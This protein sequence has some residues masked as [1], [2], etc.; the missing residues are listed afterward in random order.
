MAAV[1]FHVLGRGRGSF[2]EEVYAPLRL[3]AYLLGE[4]STAGEEPGSVRGQLGVLGPR[5][6]HGSDSYRHGRVSYE[7][8]ATKLVI[9][10]YSNLT[11]GS[12]KHHSTR[13]RTPS[14]FL[15]LLDVI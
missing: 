13:S 4:P 12:T 5:R 9:S 15:H 10:T 14:H 8:I 6:R 7:A 3:S 11:H 2:S 1:L